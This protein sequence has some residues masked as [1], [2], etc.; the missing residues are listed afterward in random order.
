VG[1]IRG[2]TRLSCG[3]TDFSGSRS[4]EI[5]EF[6]PDLKTLSRAS[7]PFRTIRL[8]F[9]LASRAERL[10]HGEPSIMSNVLSEHLGG[11]RL[12]K[13]KS[14]DLAV[15]RRRCHRRQGMHYASCYVART[16]VFTWARL[17][18][19]R[20]ASRTT[21]TDAG[22]SYTAKRRP[23]RIVYAERHSS[24]PEALKREL[25]IQTMESAKEGAARKWRRSGSIRCQPEGSRPNRIH[26]EG[27]AGAAN[28]MT[29]TPRPPVPSTRPSALRVS[30]F[31]SESPL[32]A[33][34]VSSQT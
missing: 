30:V 34:L 2:P 21:T 13:C 12:P 1:A 33:P 4:R 32:S 14:K 31:G 17:Q 22:G 10:A 29:A 16:T 25:Q 6:R 11:R 8:A 5:V 26:V 27:L 7:P 9:R 18:T 23:V 3:F 19:R 28:G 15:S 20:H 24:K